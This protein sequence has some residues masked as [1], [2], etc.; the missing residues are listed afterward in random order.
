MRASTL[1]CVVGSLTSVRAIVD[2][3]P[4][5][6]RTTAE[7]HNVAESA[8]NSAVKLLKRG[9]NYVETA[10]E[11]VKT[12]FPDATFVINDDH[13]IGT[14]GVGHVYFKQTAHGLKIQNA[15]FNVNIA[16]DGS[17]LS[18]GNSFFTG[19]IPVE[20]PLHK[21]DLVEPL[22][23]LAVASTTLHLPVG[24]DAGIVKPL[25]ANSFK[26][27]G[28]SG[29]VDE[30]DAQ[31]VY[32]VQPDKSLVLTWRLETRFENHFLA[33][34]VKADGEPTV[35][36][37]S[38]F[39]SHATYEVY[40]WGLNDP[41]EGTRV[42]VS[43]PWELTA[44]PQG[45]HTASRK[46]T[47]GNNVEAGSLATS[48]SGLV[49]FP[50]PVTGGTDSL[51]FSYPF[52]PDK[53]PPTEQNSMFAATTQIFYTLNVLHDLYYKLGFT[54]AA[55]NYQRDNAGAGGFQGD[56]VMVTIQH[57]N[58]RN[59]GQFTQSID[60]TPG[61]MTMYVFD[62]TN[63]NR[64]VAFDNGFAI[65][66]ATH[67]LSDRLTGGPRTAGCLESWEPD[68]M[69][70]GWSDL[71]S[72]AIMLKPNDTRATAE[73]GFAAWP[74]NNVNPRTARLVMYSTNMAINNFTYATVN[75]FP[76]GGKPHPVGTV[77]ASMLYEV[78]WNLIDKYGKND[79]SKPVIVNGVPQDGKY[80]M[81]KLLL[82]GFTLQPCNPSFVQARNAIIDAD[83]SLTGGKNLCE[84]WKGFAKRGLG[85][86]AVYSNGNRVDNF[87][88]PE[89]VC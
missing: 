23:A 69:A 85:R 68:G 66:E 28:L 75:Q 7:Y 39:V 33:S 41:W 22:A 16:P 51:N 87:V 53:L 70:E 78:L 71:Y 42:R 79:S 47:I 9:S 14:N 27:E 4:Y 8:S 52:T 36:G 11:L 82:D 50:E 1:F 43:D 34:F 37:V 77:W 24:A 40:P 59:N 44:S 3:S 64:D 63:P 65:H 45:W 89:G 20:N 74:L 5:R 26:I 72:A 80:L 15:D 86:D 12:I 73:Y 56:P 29:T 25:N 13:Y 83:K 21:R 32:V 55:G 54:P 30:P 49:H 17:V 46:T 31:L 62:K 76:V 6:L 60:G 48:S 81:L 67:G 61:Y 10:T 88:V 35:I 58:G 84:I 18:F 2:L 19:E 57:W 38:D